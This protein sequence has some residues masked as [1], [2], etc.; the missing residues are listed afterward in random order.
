MALTVVGMGGSSRW[1][2]RRGEHAL[3]DGGADGDRRPAHRVRS[4]PCNHD[5][6]ARADRPPRP[7]RGPHRLPHLS[8]EATRIRPTRPQHA[9]RLDVVLAVLARAE[10]ATL[11]VLL[12]TIV[13]VTRRR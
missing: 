4:P 11:V 7:H 8:R 13:T 5:T 1:G 3:A 9:A 6:G 2:V 10:T 12:V